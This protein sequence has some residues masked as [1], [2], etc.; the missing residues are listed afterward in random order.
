MDIH[1][2]AQRIPILAEAD[3]VVCGGGPAGIAAA[4]S[5]ARAGASTILIE[6]WATVGGM[7]TNAL[8]NAWHRSDREKVVIDGLV[9]ECCVR[10]EAGGW[11]RRDPGYPRVH[12]TH[13]FEPEGMTVVFHRLLDEAKV[14]TFCHLALGE[15]VVEDGRIRAVLVDTKRGRRAIAGRIFIDATGD[16]DLAVKAGMPFGY[17]R[18]EDGLVQGC[19]L[20]F[21]LHGIDPAA[22]AAAG[23]DA[24]VNAAVEVLKTMRDRGEFPPF[25][26]GNCGHLLRNARDHDLWNM[27]PV[28][29]DIL[30]EEEITRMNVLAR[31]RLVRYLEVWRREVPG[32]ASAQIER[33]G[34]A[35]G[36]RESRRVQGLKT[37][38]RDMVL[39]ARKQPDAIGHG[40]W[41]I[42]IHDPKGSGY[43]TYLNGN[44][45]WLVAGTSYHIPL[46]MCLTDRIAN[47]GFVGRCASTTHEGLSSVRVQTHCMV[48]GQGVGTCAA[49]ALQRGCD[50]TDFPVAE[51]Q[52]RLRAD[53]VHLQ[54]VPDA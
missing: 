48:M 29:G 39:Q 18:E 12:E 37:L 15:P 2:P 54:D 11:I 14:R 4:V 27:L 31:E 33:T 43:T 10:A 13:W 19:T 28:I 5:A 3:I 32:F 6:R 42:D 35:L 20:V 46:S 47:L 23:G 53:G 44:K 38:D 30:D 34:H 21:G 22:R 40:V 49:L 52:R 50:M 24:A 36:V 7:A 8:V 25:N 45:G 26:V 17:G 9:E 51:L 16:G 41:M 1:I